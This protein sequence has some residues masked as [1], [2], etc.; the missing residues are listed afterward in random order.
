M[1]GNYEYGTIPY[2]DSYVTIVV[3][4]NVGDIEVIFM[5]DRKDRYFVSQ[6]KT[7]SFISL[8]PPRTTFF[9][10]KKDYTFTSQKK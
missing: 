9:A 3:I 4:I 8:D 5:A 6:N 1:Y 2:G 10:K 7:R